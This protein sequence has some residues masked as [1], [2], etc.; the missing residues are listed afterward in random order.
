[1]SV[2]FTRKTSGTYTAS[3]GN[4]SGASSSTITGSAI[5]VR[6]REIRYKELGLSLSA[7]PTLLFTPTS[8]P[9]Y[10]HTTEF[11]LPG[12]TVVWNELTFTVKDVE[13]VAPDGY[14]IVARIIVEA[15]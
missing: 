7:C 6:G 10:S 4:F 5:Q 8:Y 13:T 1:M 14:V 15:A 3:T 11:V 2:T 9:L 12:D